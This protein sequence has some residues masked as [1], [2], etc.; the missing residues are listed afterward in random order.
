MNLVKQ[1]KEVFEQEPS[2]LDEIKNLLSLREL[3]REELA[4]LAI[5]LQMTAFVNIATLLILK[6]SL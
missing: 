4:D 1:I 5:F 6:L 3:T 2:N